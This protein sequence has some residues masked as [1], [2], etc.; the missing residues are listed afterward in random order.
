MTET[1]TCVTFQSSA[2]N[3]TE[4]GADYINPDNFGDDL[5]RWVIERLNGQSVVVDPELGQEDF[6][7]YI[8]FEAAGQAYNLILGYRYGEASNWV[9][10]LE[11]DAGLL[12][13]LFG[14]R[15]RGIM[16]EAAQAIHRVLSSSSEIQNVRWHFKQDFDAGKEEQ[17]S[18]QPTGA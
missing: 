3:T 6:G 11:R 18:T 17:S 13:S 4:T 8:T 2:F 15:R 9:G 14:A 10:W 12:P 1:R 7:W 16:P 5:A